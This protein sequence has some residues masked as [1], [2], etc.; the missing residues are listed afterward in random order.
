MRVARPMARGR[1]RLRVGPSSAKAAR[2]FRSSPTSSWLCSALATA[3]SSSLLQSRATARGVKARI[4]RASSTDL[5]R[6]WSQTRR[7]LRAEVRT[8]LAWART[9]GAAPLV[10]AAARRGLAS[11]LGGAAASSPAGGLAR[12]PPPPGPRLP[13]R[14]GLGVGLGRLLGVGLLRARTARLGLLELLDAL[15]REHV[16]SRLVDAR[17]RGS[18]ALGLGLGRAGFLLAGR[19]RARHLRGLGLRDLLL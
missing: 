10:A 9:T 19:R 15:G 2:T 13:G 1:K 6:M 16:G 12:A 18:G 11:A 7:A 14:L 4:A 5:P 3:D 8:Y 17:G